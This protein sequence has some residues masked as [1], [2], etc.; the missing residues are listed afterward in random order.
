MEIFKVW[1]K[2]MFMHVIPL[3]CVEEISLN[4]VRIYAW[5]LRNHNVTN[6]Q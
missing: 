6:A 1:Q 4:A 2:S 5:L 3:E